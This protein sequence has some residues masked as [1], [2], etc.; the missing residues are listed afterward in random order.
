MSIGAPI[1]ANKEISITRITQ[2]RS[3]YLISVHSD[4]SWFDRAGRLSI[5]PDIS[6]IEPEN[7][8]IIRR[9]TLGLRLPSK[10]CAFSGSAVIFELKFV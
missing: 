9:N 4:L 8:S 1:D 2:D 6:I 7:L 3:I 10:G 5:K